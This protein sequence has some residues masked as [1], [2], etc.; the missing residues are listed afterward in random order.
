M[1]TRKHIQI[2]RALLVTKV[3]I[4]T[5]DHPLLK[6]TCRRLIQK[7]QLLIATRFGC[8]TLSLQTLTST[9]SLLMQSYMATRL[10]PTVWRKTHLFTVGLRHSSICACSVGVPSHS[11]SPDPAKICWYFWIK[12]LLVFHYMYGIYMY[13]MAN[14]IGY[15]K[16]ALIT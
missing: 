15:N 9:G 4:D 16:H 6:R 2:K 8:I 13:C 14:T 7:S 5:L 1:T 10:I 3:P 11:H 12:R